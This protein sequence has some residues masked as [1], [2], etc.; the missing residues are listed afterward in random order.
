MYYGEVNIHN[1]DLNEFLLVSEELQIEG[2]AQ[3]NIMA[4]KNKNIKE[5]SVLQVVM[6]D[7][8]HHS[9]SAP[10]KKR[11][12]CEKN[13]FYQVQKT[14]P[15]RIEFWFL[16]WNQSQVIKPFLRLL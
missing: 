6:K 3:N 4:N 15:M 11:K 10:P 13:F 5:K 16:I 7:K 1:D 12:K 2:L 8:L 14:K 9:D